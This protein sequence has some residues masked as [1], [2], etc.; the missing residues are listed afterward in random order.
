MALTDDFLIKKGFTITDQFP[1]PN[2]W[3]D[4]VNGKIKL[5]KRPNE[6]WT[7]AIEH[8][9]DYSEEFWLTEEQ[10]IYDLLNALNNPK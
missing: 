6:E 10:Q 9:H 7:I 1:A 5:L 8:D 2:E 3:K 4:A